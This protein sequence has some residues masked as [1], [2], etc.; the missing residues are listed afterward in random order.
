MP[1]LVTRA[2]GPGWRISNRVGEH[3]CPI[4]RTT[5]PTDERPTRFPQIPTSAKLAE[6]VAWILECAGLTGSEHR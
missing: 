3:T 6:A 2:A 4:S 5:P 1:F